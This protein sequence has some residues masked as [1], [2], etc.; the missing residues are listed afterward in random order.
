MNSTEIKRN[1]PELIQNRDR[2]Y[3]LAITNVRPVK[4]EM[5]NQSVFENADNA[6]C[7]LP[8]PVETKHLS[9]QFM[10]GETFDRS[11]IKLI[12]QCNE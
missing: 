2:N 6:L 7:N 12:S 8:K 10:L 5:S 4:V 11:L 3:F 9:L 1:K